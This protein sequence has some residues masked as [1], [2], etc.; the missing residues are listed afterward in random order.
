MQKKLCV[1]N[2]IQL[3]VKIKQIVPSQWIIKLSASYK[4]GTSGMW[5][6]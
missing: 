5:S 6:A 1:N 2:W 3:C 4:D